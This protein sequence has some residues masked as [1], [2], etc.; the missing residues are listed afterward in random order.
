MKVFIPGISN[1]TYVMS[2]CERLVL[3][4]IYHCSRHKQWEAMLKIKQ[5]IRK[6]PWPSTGH[7]VNEKW[8]FK[9]FD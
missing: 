6:W 2:S 3:E 8:T 1:N 9:L 7:E 4:N 5:K